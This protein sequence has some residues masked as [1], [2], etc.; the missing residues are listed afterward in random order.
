MPQGELG[1][2]NSQES[3][4]TSSMS[5]LAPAELFKYPSRVQTFLEKYMSSSPF[6]LVKGG[7]VTLMHQQHVHQV[8]E[9]KD[10]VGA[11]A[12]MLAGMDGKF[13]KLS[14]F[15]KTV[16][17]GGKSV[18]ATSGNAVY[19]GRLADLDLSKYDLRSFSTISTPFSQGVLV[20]NIKETSDVFAVSDFNKA[21]NQVLDRPE[22]ITLTCENFRFENVIGCVPVTN[23]EPKADLVLVGMDHHAMKL[24]PVGY[25]SYKM[26]ARAKD[27]QNYSGLS[28][29][30]SPYIFQHPETKK[31]YE[32]LRNFSEKSVYPD[33]YQIIEDSGI[34]GM[35]VWGM[36]YGK[37]FGVNNCHFIAQGTVTIS[38]SRLSY[39][40]SHRN[41]DFN[42][43]KE[44]TPVFGARYATGRTN[45]GPGNISVKNY[46]IGIFPRAYRTSWLSGT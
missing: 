45:K 38:G 29:K 17:F 44:Y 36:D 27:F 2:I 16:E 21:L 24:L 33:S 5:T 7:E 11:R 26:G 43:S 42:F 37:A 22:G 12:L 35:A 23:G 46:R 13:Y 19:Y 39:T 25:L 15:K 20:H 8:I 10:A 9:R 1:G 3:S 40:H 28:E 41:G 32:T 30:S 14:D 31:F 34:I 6:H 4:H 18:S